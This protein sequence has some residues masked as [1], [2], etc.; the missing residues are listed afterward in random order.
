MYQHSTENSF[1]CGEEV[2]EDPFCVIIFKTVKSETLK[3]TKNCLAVHNS[4]Y[5]DQGLREIFAHYIKVYPG[6]Q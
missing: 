5:S 2:I 6:F 4:S 3:H 1:R